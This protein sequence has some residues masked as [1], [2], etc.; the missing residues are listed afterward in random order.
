MKYADV[1]SIAACVRA[2]C[3]DTCKG[4]VGLGLWPAS[5]CAAAPET[6]ES[7]SGC[8]IAGAGSAAATV[9]FAAGLSAMWARRRR[10][11]G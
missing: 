4:E 10:R 7:S 6:K 2:Q 8:A 11:A 3:Q 1:G 5:M 9:A